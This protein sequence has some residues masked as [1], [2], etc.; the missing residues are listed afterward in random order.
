MTWLQYNVRIS[1]YLSITYVQPHREYVC[2]YSSEWMN[3]WNWRTYINRK[4]GSVVDLVMQGF[5]S[6]SGYSGAAEVSMSWCWH[7]PHHHV[8]TRNDW[9]TI[10]WV[11]TWWKISDPNLGQTKSHPLSESGCSLSNQSQ[12]R[13][14]IARTLNQDQ[15]KKMMEWGAA[16]IRIN[17]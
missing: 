5:G 10:N 3:F 11:S 4:M 13:L 2:S 6:L 1:K 14:G 16:E 9:K 8:D 15:N 17:L 12:C 7:L